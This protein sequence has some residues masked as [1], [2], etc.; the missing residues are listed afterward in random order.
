MSILGQIAHALLT[1]AIPALEQSIPAVK[2]TFAGVI[3]YESGQTVPVKLPW[4][5]GTINL[6]KAA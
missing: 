5:L 3:A 6:T 1:A 2:N 4:G